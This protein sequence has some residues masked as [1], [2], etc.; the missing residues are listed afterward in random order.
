MN[1]AFG[2]CPVGSALERLA[3]A[4]PAAYVQEYLK[5]IN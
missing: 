3:H 1:D 2:V 5:P 4:T